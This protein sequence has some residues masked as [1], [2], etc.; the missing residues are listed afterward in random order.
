MASGLFTS[1]AS[2]LSKCLSRHSAFAAQLKGFRVV[3]PAHAF[4]ARA[5]QVEPL[6]QNPDRQHIS[7]APA[8]PSPRRRDCRALDHR[9]LAGAFELAAEVIV[10]H[11]RRIKEA[12]ELLKHLAPREDRRVAIINAE[13]PPP[14]VETREDAAP[15]VATFEGDCE[16]AADDFWIADYFF[17]SG[18][19]IGGKLCVGVQ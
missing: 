14:V 1:V 4:G 19:G 15:E 3:N 11:D 9:C 2:L 6:Q 17:D 7:G 10:F 8:A 16:V 13:P 18:N 12:A 5:D